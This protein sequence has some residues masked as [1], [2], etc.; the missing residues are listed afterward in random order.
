MKTLLNRKNALSV[1]AAIVI[2]PLVWWTSAPVRGH[3]MARYDIAR[4]RYRILVYGAIPGRSPYYKTLLHDRYGIE[5]EKI[6]GCVDSTSLVFYADAYNRVSVAAAN[7]KFGHDVFKE[8]SDEG[9][10][11]WQEGYK[12]ELQ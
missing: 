8:C 9:V 12:A 1:I 4:G 7:R 2:V 11:R 3:L 10:K 6:A 5:V